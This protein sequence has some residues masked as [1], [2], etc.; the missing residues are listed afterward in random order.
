M[1]D[2]RPFR[3]YPAHGAFYSPL[4]GGPK[5][6]AP[7]GRWELAGSANELP[8]GLLLDVAMREPGNGGVSPD[9]QTWRDR[10]TAAEMEAATQRV[11]ITELESKLATAERARDAAAANAEKPLRK[12]REEIGKLSGQL[13]ELARMTA[14]AYRREDD[15]TDLLRPPFP[16][17]E[18][19]VT[20]EELYEFAAEM[21]RRDH[22]SVSYPMPS[23]QTVTAA[24]TTLRKH[25]GDGA[26]IETALSAVL[27]ALA[28]DRREQAGAS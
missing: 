10:A 13:Y 22:P 4:D 3:Y 26:S 28:A 19:E 5:W 7:F 25:I 11:R 23:A 18:E 16:E 9:G 17:M 24:S 21:L 20:P 14:E 6:Q 1:T 12:A 8:Q 15:F 27:A 2:H